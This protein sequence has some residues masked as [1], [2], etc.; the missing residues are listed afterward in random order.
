MADS[1]PM[2]SLSDAMHSLGRRPGLVLGSAATC[3]PGT[4]A[5]IVMQAFRQGTSGEFATTATVD[6][7]PAVLDDLQRRSP[8]QAGKVSN[9]L[10]DGL[11]SL[12]PSLDLPYLAKAGWSACVSLTQDVLFEAALRNYLD[13][14]PT[15]RSVTIVDSV[16]TEPPERTIP[17]Y[18]LLGNLNNGEE[19]SQLVLSTSSALVRQQTWPRLLR[20]CADYLREAPLFFVGTEA[21]V[22][23]VRIVLSALL[24][25][26]KPSVTRLLFLRDDNTLKDATVLAL[27][28]QYRTEIIDASLREL[29]NAVAELKPSSLGTSVISVSDKSLAPIQHALL[30]HQSTISIV[31]NVLP[32]H[33]DAARNRLALVDGLFRPTSIDW[34]PFLLDMDLRRSIASSIKN[35]VQSLLKQPRPHVGYLVTHGEAGIGKSILLKRVAVELSKSGVTTLWCRRAQSDNWPRHYRKLANDLAQAIKNDGKK[36]QQFAIFCDDPWASRLDAGELMACF[37][38]FPAPVAFVFAVRNTAYFTADGVAIAIKG[39]QNP[40]IEIPY[41]L[42]DAEIKGLAGLLLRIG[43]VPDEPRAKEEIAKIR[44]R[45]A[46]DILCSL[47]Y[48]IPE[49]RSQLTQSLRDEFCR[50]GEVRESLA[51]AAQQISLTSAIAHRAYEYVTVTSHLDIGLPVEVL[52][53]ALGVNYEEWLDTSADGRPLWGLLYDEM[54]EER[55]TVTYRT[56]NEVVTNILLDLVNGGVGH[57]GEV[58]V[59]R[60]LLTACDVGSAAYRGFVLDVLV[61]GRPK[62]AKYLSFDQ[63]LELFEAARKALPHTDRVIEHHKGIWIDDIGHD[64]A[65]AYAQFEAALQ[66][67]VYPGADRDAPKEHIHTSMAATVVRMVK[68]GKQDREAGFE[69][70]K[71]HLRQASSAR[72]FNAHTAHVSA[73]L[74]FE[75]AQHGDKA[76]SDAVSLSSLSEALQEIEKGLQLIGAHGRGQYKYEKSI[77]LLNELQRKILQ[78]IPDVERLKKFAQE[79]FDSA[80]SQIGFEAVGRRLLADAIQVDKGRA[81]NDVNA[82]LQECIRTIVAKGKEPSPE[83]LMIRVDL[84]IRW[85]IQRPSGS[86]DWKSF[87]NDLYL[88]LK[89][90]RF[91]DDVVKQFYYAVAQYHCQ[92]I[93][94]ANATFGSLRRVVQPT[95]TPHAIRCYFSGDEGAPRRFQG[96]V[97]RHHLNYYLVIPELNSSIPAR[98]QSVGGGPGATAHAYIGF[99]LNG[100]VAVFDRPDDSA[101]L[102][103]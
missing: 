91:V 60:E 78:A 88:V 71:D 29:C 28:G 56:R 94:E 39:L 76:A 97:E 95:L 102:L 1:I 66:A 13:T 20:T 8:E 15:S 59:L 4:M 45:N 98:A 74:Y 41:E 53:R 86:I 17:I 77:V 30:A 11:R 50:L 68:E 32:Q 12:R 22:P 27:S 73:N 2:I 62:L 58:R 34:N 26:Q 92:E 31:P 51:S 83:L 79:K 18:K 23:L 96:T 54:D 24:S 101:S 33:V 67:P 57:G 9:E 84:I 42:D 75:L 100:P 52:V 82:Y 21:E 99:S 81:Y 3:L 80:G 10:R 90:R 103:P 7:Y 48:L 69:T 65:T 85:R 40:E 63:G 6:S 38:N 93:T 25:M 5:T 35:Q 72:F 46:K 16:R 49:T 36:D 87:K 44:S 37:E 64:R 43:A 55:S 61:R 70:V 89:S 14:I 19:D 47:W